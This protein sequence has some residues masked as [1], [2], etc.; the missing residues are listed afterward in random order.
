MKSKEKKRLVV[1]L[2]VVILLLLIAA[3]ALYVVK[4]NSRA[5]AVTIPL[6]TMV[7]NMCI[8]KNLP[9]FCSWVWIKKRQSL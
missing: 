5:K 7:K 3:V 4:N 1:I 6:L 9:I 8:I 2:A